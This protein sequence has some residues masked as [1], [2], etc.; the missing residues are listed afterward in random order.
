MGNSETH[1]AFFRTKFPQSSSCLSRR[2]LSLYCQGEAFAVR[3]LDISSEIAARTVKEK[4]LGFNEG[5]PV[6]PGGVYK[7]LT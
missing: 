6:S 7:D 5:D 2:Q 4:L 3:V 1:W